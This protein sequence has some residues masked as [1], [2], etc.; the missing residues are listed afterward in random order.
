M[1]QKISV[2]NQS[3]NAL[4]ENIP[5]YQRRLFWAV[6]IFL[7]ISLSLIP[8]IH[9]I[10]NTHTNLSL[11]D[12]MFAVTGGWLFLSTEWLFGNLN[13]IPKFVHMAY[14]VLIFYMIFK[15]RGVVLTYPIIYMTVSILS[16]LLSYDFYTHFK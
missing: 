16:T 14:V 1:S 8:F 10:E 4:N 5:W 2:Q 9:L 6:V 3:L 7:Q 15:K 13:S 11:L 12:A